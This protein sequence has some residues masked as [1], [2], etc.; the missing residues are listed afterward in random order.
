MSDKTRHQ[1]N[2]VLMCFMIFVF[3]LLCVL[4]FVFALLWALLCALVIAMLARRNHPMYRV[5]KEIWDARVKKFKDARARKKREADQENRYQ[6]EFVPDRMLVGIG[7]H[8]GKKYFI[9]K[10]I[11]VI[12][13]KKSCQ[14]VLGDRQASTISGEHCRITYRK[15]SRTYYIEDLHSLN[16]T[17]LGAKR[18]EPNTPEKL[19]DNAEISI[20]HIR[21]CFV[22]QK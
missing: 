9:D 18:L 22:R 19:L 7:D 3:L 10:E 12:G 4:Q 13:T 15:H 20:G 21:F 1:I 16:G 11:F 2:V 8:A 6:N 17:Y 14:C 5:E